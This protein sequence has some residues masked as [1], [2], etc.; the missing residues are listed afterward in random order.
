MMVNVYN[1]S[2]GNDTLTSGNFAS[3][4]WIMVTSKNKKT[5]VGTYRSKLINYILLQFLAK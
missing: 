5:H 2:E 3:K 4:S 1:V